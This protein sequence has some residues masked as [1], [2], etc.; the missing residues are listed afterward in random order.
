MYRVLLTK[1]AIK[2]QELII[3]AGLGKQAKKL[4]D[5][6]SENPYQNPPRYE[7]LIGQLNGYYSRRINIHHRLVYQVNEEEH[8]VIVYAMWTHYQ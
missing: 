5:I 2:D 6:I 4:L 8:I 7:K 1:N 3:K